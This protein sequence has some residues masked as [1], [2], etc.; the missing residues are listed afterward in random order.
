MQTMKSEMEDNKFV[1]HRIKKRRIT[2]GTQNRFRVGIVGC[3]YQ[4][5][6]LAQ[7]IALTDS[8]V[9]TACA[10]IDPEAAAGL[11]IRAGNASIHSSVE[12]LLS[13]ANV[14]IVMVATPH[15]VLAEISLRRRGGK[16]VLVEKPV[17]MN[18][19][20]AAAVGR[21]CGEFDICYMAGYSFRYLPAWQ[22]VYELPSPGRFG[23]IQAVTGSF[24]L[25]PM[26]SGW[27]Q[28][29]DGRG[30]LLFLGSH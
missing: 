2:M 4:G 15:H 22:K 27:I 11:A 19:Q 17:G 13:N 29:R 23:E 5:D 14:D 1:I 25:G 6:R 7:A 12:D 28:N 18:E 10:D 20:E 21:S 3:G 30:P 9:V 26:N 24:G 16:H 8:M